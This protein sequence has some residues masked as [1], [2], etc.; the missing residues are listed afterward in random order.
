M[1]WDTDMSQDA[2]LQ[3]TAIETE[4]CLSQQQVIAIQ[5]LAGGDTVT[6]AAQAAEVARE[7]VHRWLRDDVAF[8]TTVN[9]AKGDIR[10]AAERTLLVVVQQAAVNLMRAVEGGNL[11]ASIAVLK[12]LGFLAGEKPTVGPTDPILLAERRSEQ[13]A[14]RKLEKARARAVREMLAHA[15]PF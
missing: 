6:A 5:R 9:R 14:D 7:T 8:L 1:G 2:T 10:D 12:G 4:P 11:Q 3:D 13:E 15:S